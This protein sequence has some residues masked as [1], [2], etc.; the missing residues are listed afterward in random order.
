M[1]ARSDTSPAYEA[2]LIKAYQR[3]NPIQKLELAFEMSQMVM[4]LARAGIK[5]RHPGISASE[6]NLRLGA[7]V[8]GRELSIRINQW[9]PEQEGY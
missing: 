1:T 5:S 8:L 9:D 7:L 6:L 4:D 3:L 2:F